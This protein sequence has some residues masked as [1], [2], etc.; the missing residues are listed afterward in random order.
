VRPI[1]FFN[2]VEYP[3]LDGGNWVLDA[4]LVDSFRL[5]PREDISDMDAAYG[6][7]QLARNELVAYA[8]GE[9]NELNDEGFSI[10]LRALRAVLK[11]LGVE[12]KPRFRDLARF[13]DYWISVGMDGSY[14]R[15]RNYLNDLFD[16]VF[17]RLEQLE[18][19]QATTSIRGVDGQLKNIIFA[20]NGPKPRIV[21][22]PDV[23]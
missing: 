14:A 23:S 21:L 15:R 12:F 22:S 11:R 2:W 18:D 16:P 5:R 1:D 6:L 3:D 13:R 4:D 10:V 19:E 17:S 7:A 9:Q 8:T 20:S